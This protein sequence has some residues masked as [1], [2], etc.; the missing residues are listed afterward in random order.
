MEGT[1][2][3][4]GVALSTWQP[5]PDFGRVK[6]LLD[7]ARLAEALGY[8][9]LWAADHVTVPYGDVGRLGQR[10]FDPVV[11]LAYLAA[12]TRRIRLGTDVL[13]LPYRHPLVVAKTIATLDR[14]SGG[15]VI[16]GV[17]TGYIEPEFRA[18][19]VP[20]DTRGERMDECLRVIRQVWSGQ[21]GQSFQGRFF[22]FTAMHVEPRPVQQPHP[23]IWVAGSGPRVIRRAVELAEGWHPL[24]PSLEELDAGLRIMRKA[25]RRAGRRHPPHVSISFRP[26]HIEYGAASG[27]RRPTGQR[28][29]LHGTPEEA[30]ADVRELERRGV[31]HLVLRFPPGDGGAQGVAHAMERFVREVRQPL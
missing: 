1:T 22:S 3:Q 13:V 25:C 10:W 11:L 18:L 31:G 29:L 14:L 16:L 9:S 26:V 12:H 7:L 17:G 23:P 5:G 8:D 15:R 28:R 6:T 24:E 30:M 27:R 4:F 20:Y 21:G 19:S 2:M